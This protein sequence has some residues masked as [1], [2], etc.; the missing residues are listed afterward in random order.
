MSDRNPLL[1]GLNL[2]IQRKPKRAE[3]FS[4]SAEVSRLDTLAALLE[5]GNEDARKSA[6][7]RGVAQLDRRRCRFSPQR[8]GR[9]EGASREACLFSKFIRDV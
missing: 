2:P 1:S 9:A 5:E 7:R 8:S 3:N 4:V 6:Q